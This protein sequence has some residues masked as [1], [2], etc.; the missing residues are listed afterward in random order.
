M[1]GWIC[2]ISLPER[3]GMIV[4]MCVFVRIPPIHLFPDRFR[5]KPYPTKQKEGGVEFLPLQ[6]LVCGPVCWQMW[7]ISE[8]PGSTLSDHHLS[9]LG[10]F[11]MG[12]MYSLSSIMVWN[13][14]DGPWWATTAE[15]FKSHH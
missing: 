13:A 2:A 1:G 5:V 12:S 3:G 14:G 10:P 15:T 9:A 6:D 4:E 7:C 11:S 8:F